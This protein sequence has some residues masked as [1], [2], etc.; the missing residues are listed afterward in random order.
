MEGAAGGTGFGGKTAG[1]TLKRSAARRRNRGAVAPSHQH[2][3]LGLAEI[4]DGD[5]KPYSD[6]G[7]RD[8]EGEGR[9]VGKHAMAEFVRF[10]GGSFEAR[11]ILRRLPRRIFRRMRRSAR[12]EFEHAM[13]VVRCKGLL[14]FHCCQFREGPVSFST[15]AMPLTENVGGGFHM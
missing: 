9:D 2:A 8:G 10:L 7:Q 5:R 14:G 6:R 1:F 11:E 3:I 4:A 13:L 15:P 12:P